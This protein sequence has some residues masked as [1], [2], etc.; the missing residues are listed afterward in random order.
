MNRLASTGETA[1]PCGVPRSR[2]RKV[3]SGSA[4][5]ALSHRLTYSTTHG[6]SAWAW[7]AL[8]MSACSTLSN[9]APSYYRPRGPSVGGADHAAASSVAGQVVTGVGRDA[10]A[11]GRGVA[12]GAAR[13]QQIADPG[14]LD[15]CGAGR[16]GR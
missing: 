8:T 11:R 12:A 3:P 7:T 13:W 4:S 10:A 5:G 15:R 6:T 16:R 1:Y 14:G 2:C 9:D